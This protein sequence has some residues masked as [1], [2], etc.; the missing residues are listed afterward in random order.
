MAT[1]V[2]L[3]ARAVPASLRSYQTPVKFPWAV[4]DRSSTEE[5]RLVGKF[6]VNVSHGTLLPRCVYASK[7]MDGNVVGNYQSANVAQQA[8]T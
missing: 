4:N 3:W 8:K 7:T 2:G 1:L 5:T 6:V